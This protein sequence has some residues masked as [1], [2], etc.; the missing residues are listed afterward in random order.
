MA[1]NVRPTDIEAADRFLNERDEAFNEGGTGIEAADSNSGMD[2]VELG[3]IIA[4]ELID[5]V[6]YV[7]LEI[8]VERAR[9]TKA[10]RGDPYGDEEDGRSSLVSRDVHDTIQGQLPDL[11]R[12]LVGSEAPCEYTAETPADVAWT[13]QA[14]SYAQYIVEQD[15]DGFNVLY[16][17]IKDALTY[18][19]GIV[20]FWWD[21]SE[22]VRTEHYTALD[23]VSVFLLQQDGTIED[24][25][26]EEHEPGDLSLPPP[27][28]AAPAPP[29]QPGMPPQAPQ[30]PPAPPTLYDVT[31]RRRITHGRVKLLP[32]PPEEFI[33]D[34]RALGLYEGGFTLC[35][36]R[37]MKT[38]SE[39]VAMG[40]D[41]DEIRPFVTSPELDTN[42]EYIE[43]QPYARAVGSFDS[44]NPATQRVLYVEAYT[45]VDWDGD[46]IAELRK[47]CVMGPSYKVVH[48]EAVDHVPF[49]DFHVDPEP[50]TFYGLSTADK[51]MDIQ[52]IKT[53]IQRNLLD[54]LAQS[55]HPR[56][57][58][59][60]GQVNVDDVMNNEVGG[61]VRQR[62]PGMVQ[63]LDTPF[64]GQQ[65]LP[66]LDY[67]DSTREM[68]T[69]VSRQQLG[70]EADALQSTNQMAIE[71]SISGSQGKIEL[72]ARVMANGMR[73][74][75][76]GIL[77]L[78]VQN[79]D[80]P[81]IIPLNGTFVPMDPRTWRSDIGVSITVALG[82]GSTQQKLQ[83]LG[84]ILQK[85]ELIFTT[86]GMNQPVVSPKQYATALKKWTELS[87]W[88]N[89]DMFFSDVPDGWQPP[90]PPPPPE[91]PKVTIAK[92]QLQMA[93]QKLDFEREKAM[94]AEHRERDKNVSDAILRSREIEV[95]YKG[96]KENTA[97]Q[98]AA[99]VKQA[100]I[101]AH[102][103]HHD[104]AMHENA[105]SDRALMGH[106][107][108]LHTTAITAA[109]KP[110]P[111][112]KKPAK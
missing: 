59:V 88:R 35:G 95:N 85:Q 56:T 50:H 69:G 60:E 62:A 37:S 57:T 97:I 55:I 40:Y 52:R 91:D 109:A 30:P 33:I 29:Q 68:R 65:A 58:I 19:T 93:Q 28:P 15:N 92:M 24:M 32:L 5:A 53:H 31:V 49:A 18:K 78:I 100:T 23:E 21:T 47:V 67:I 61:I 9:A 87:G 106:M 20:K 102:A 71:Q 44:L 96:Q 84:L 36:H 70:L 38:V 103:G 64:V 111:T 8:G 77:H 46:G 27:P 110:A 16:S 80:R 42:V 22:E 48:H 73:K 2:E 14:T 105:E 99:G 25:D 83:T 39:L 112:E 6:R 12:I 63:T 104:N 107:T 3:A 101:Q 81:R 11:L 94:W 4:G 43:R 45:W 10:Y 76:K 75:F 90:P 86:M 98:A 17:A 79:Q 7:D 54:S 74:L 72:I 82:S 26:I 13:E 41:P 89:S 66:V 1:R 51:T 34:R 108:D